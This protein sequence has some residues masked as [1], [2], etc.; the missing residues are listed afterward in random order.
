LKVTDRNNRKNIVIRNGKMRKDNE[1]ISKNNPIPDDFIP[2][3][4]KV[5]NIRKREFMDNLHSTSCSP[6]QGV[7]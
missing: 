1:I 2:S 5:E 4:C 3:D 7:K 6:P